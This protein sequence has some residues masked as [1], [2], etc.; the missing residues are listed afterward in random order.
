MMMEKRDNCMQ[1]EWNQTTILHYSQSLTQ[2]L[3]KDGNIRPK[4]IEVLEENIR[5]RLPNISLGNGFLDLTPKAKATKSKINKCENIKLKSFCTA[6]ETS[7]MKRQP[8]EWE[9]IFANH[10]SDKGLTA[11]MYTNSIACKENKQANKKLLIKNGQRT[12][13]D[14]FPK[15]T[16]KWTLGT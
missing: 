2:K 4:T 11:E 5:S 3:F 1:K 13:I 14:I 15:G 8:T 6:K 16:Q 10:V 12:W 9:K 7:K